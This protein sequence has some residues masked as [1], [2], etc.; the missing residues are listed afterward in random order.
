MIIISGW[1]RCH[2]T[3]PKQ[4][5]KHEQIQKSNPDSSIGNHI[6]LLSFENFSNSGKF[7]QKKWIVYRGKPGLGKLP[8]KPFGLRFFF[9]VESCRISY[10][11]E[12]DNSFDGKTKIKR[13]YFCL[14]KP[15]FENGWN[16][17]RR[18]SRNENQRRSDA[19][20]KTNESR[21]I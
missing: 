18:E 17:G 19:N 4:K 8:K 6:P 7:I 13:K 15:N 20:I 11:I 9:I 3:D 2:T 16:S 12:V 1:K 5:R 10:K 14:L 21:T